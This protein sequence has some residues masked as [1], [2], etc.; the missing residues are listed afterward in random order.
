MKGADIAGNFKNKARLSIEAGCEMILVCNNRSGALE[1]LNFFEENKIS[2]T[3]KVY[4]M[5]MSKDISWSDLDKSS[6]RNEIRNELVN[7][8]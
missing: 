5:L 6:E 2:K 8:I 4:S 1:V 3:E 7:L